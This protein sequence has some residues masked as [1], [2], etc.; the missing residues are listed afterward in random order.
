MNKKPVLA[1]CLACAMT[2]AMLGGCTAAPAEPTPEPT[3]AP[4][5]A[6]TEA[7]T[8]EPTAEPVELTIFAAASM[9]ESLNQIA[10]MYKEVAPNV[11]LVFNFDS[12]G[13]LK[14]QIQEGAE[15]DA[16]I[17]AGQ[18]QMNQLDITA[19]ADVNTESLDFV[20]AATRFN[21]VTNTVVLIV[22]NG[23]TK[24]ITSFDDV[25]TDKVGLIALGNSDVPVGQ[26][27]QDVFTY[28]GVWDKLND[29]KKI[30]F[31]TNVKEVLT[32][33]ETGAVDCGVVYIS[34][35]ATSDGVTVVAAAPEGSHKPVSY[36][37][38]VLKTSQNPEAAAA[39][40]DFLKTDACSAV[41]TGIGFGIPEK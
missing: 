37:A 16:F 32:Q 29:E 13:T 40:L 34:D 7:P 28:M 24:G 36:P 11:T 15:A 35:A 41:F 26:Y 3:V 4:T 23:S 30:S 8:P 18:L 5:V 10:E 31:G 17:S 38:A 1:L 33:V 25:A 20:D 21:L 27:S 2:A 22:P 14:T 9:T 12:S 39:F 19:A 6:P